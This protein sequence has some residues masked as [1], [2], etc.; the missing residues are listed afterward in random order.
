MATLD[1]KL[2]WIG[3]TLPDRIERIHTPEPEEVFFAPFY[4]PDHEEWGVQIGTNY[5]GWQDRY[6]QLTEAPVYLGKRFSTL[7]DLAA[8]MVTALRD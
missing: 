8:W 7:E 6:D 4:D 2:S 5:G 1:E 3:R